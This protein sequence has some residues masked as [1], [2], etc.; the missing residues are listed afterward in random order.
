MPHLKSRTPYLETDALL[1]LLEDDRDWLNNI[2][3]IM[4]RT[5]ITKLQQ[6]AE[7]LDMYTQQFLDTGSVFI[8]DVTHY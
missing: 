4:S 8:P 3:N 7:R 1:A 6:A 2:L 5:E